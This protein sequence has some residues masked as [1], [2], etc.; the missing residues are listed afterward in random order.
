LFLE[1]QKG[2]SLAA[3]PT[4]QKNLTGPELKHYPLFLLPQ[5]F[6]DKK[7]D[8]DT[9]IIKAETSKACFSNTSSLDTRDC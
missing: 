2:G 5:F 3:P 4:R 7:E 9:K 1:N 8:N 6:L